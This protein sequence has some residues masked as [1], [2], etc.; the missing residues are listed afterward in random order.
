MAL[1]VL[2]GMVFLLPWAWWA[3]RRIEM[4]NDV[5][6]WLPDND[7]QS[8]ILDWYKGEFPVEDR[9]LVS[10]DGSSLN[11]PRVRRLAFKLQ[12]RQSSRGADGR[13]PAADYVADIVTPQQAVGRIIRSSR[14]S[15]S[16]EEA[17]RRLEGVLVGWGPLK[18]ELTQAG[19]ARKKHAI[20]TLKARI[21][22]ELGVEV[23]ISDAAAA[24]ERVRKFTANDQKLLDRDVARMVEGVE[25]EDLRTAIGEA[26][27]EFPTSPP[28]HLLVSWR[29]M[30]PGSETSQQI[31][32][33]AG[34]LRGRKSHN[35]PEGE[36]W[37]A[38]TFYY[39]GSPV[40]LFVTLNE[41]GRE[42]THDAMAAL[43]DAAADVGIP[44]EDLHL[45][46]RPV[47]GS[48][49][50]REVKRAAWNPDAPLYLLHQRSPLLLSA[51]VGIV[52]AFLM[53]RSARLATLVL[54]VS[55]FTVLITVALV[56]ITN[57]SMNMVL[58]VM[59]TLLYVLTISAAIHVANYWKHAAYR[60]MRTAVVQAVKMARQP[61][62]LASVTTAIGLA[63]LLTSPLTPVRDF[64]LYSAIGCLI[65]LLVILVCLPALLQFWPGR[66]PEL[67]E[68]DR[69]GWKAL[70][71]VLYR[72]RFAVSALF[73]VAFAVCTLGLRWFRTETKVI[74]YFP[75][76]S[77]VVQDYHFLE[78]NL[79]GIIPVDVV[80]RFHL[81]GTADDDENN[82]RTPQEKLDVLQR[83]EI[84]R[85][86]EEKLR[87]HREISGVVSLPD[88]RPVNDPPPKEA[89]ERLAAGG[90]SL[91]EGVKLRAK[92]R[93]YN[94][95]LLRTNAAL[96]DDL[97]RTDSK[98]K[99]FMVR[100]GGEAR[101]QTAGG[102][103]FEVNRGDEVW[104]ITAQVAVMSDA[105]YAQL[106]DELNAL[107]Q[108]TLKYHPDADHVVTGMVPV[109]LRT[110]EAVL[111]SLIRSFGL[112]FAVIAVVMMIVLRNPFAGLIAM[113]PNLLPVGVVF[114]L[115]SWAGLFVDIGTMITASVALG[116]AVDGTLHLLTWFKQ[117]IAD[118]LDREQA[119][120]QALAHCAP[121]MWQTSAAVG[122][123][124][125]MLAPAELLLIHRF[126]WL[127]ASLIAAALIGDVVF[128]PALL[129]GP[130]GGMI[131]RTI[132]RGAPASASEAHGSQPVGLPAAEDSPGT[133]GPH[134]LN[135]QGPS[136][137]VLRAD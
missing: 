101:L 53:L 61:C 50:N 33:I 25:D 116:I 60:D 131:E 11:D 93:G 129:G 84:V 70:G 94:E 68:I 52:L 69:T 8:R 56:P 112:A 105:N 62:L 12:D 30:G 6:N 100:T 54:V 42:D 80:V 29:G 57:G 43:R 79:A 67:R 113:L 59:P 2:L 118:G 66:K 27:T 119:V 36:A 9:V 92:V 99:S 7:P 48:E 46:G 13:H 22:E 10:W 102:R 37:V 127:M 134:V 86:I 130:L 15:V 124:L 73:L 5:T 103:Q 28:H 77:R 91:L 107:V 1:W 40:A 85:Q 31:R 108:S 111:S 78:D 104:R 106:S 58:V 63:S 4:R 126:G 41:A 32:G 19:R 133:A 55:Q 132:R 71:G 20:Q 96:T 137:R 114:G 39:P 83:M 47:A 87:R 23:T 82:P 65:S 89:L 34:N 95:R 121:A 136:G 72:H 76:D 81:D 120:K 90:F 16:R 97:K 44:A 14:N 117:G 51:I 98:V 38:R 74:R 64:G 17:I 125:L 18:V 49:L 115:I 3:I 122:I 45:G 110:Q 109:F 21:A 35:H 123:G 24:Q 88:F 75:D 26:V 135:V 128:L